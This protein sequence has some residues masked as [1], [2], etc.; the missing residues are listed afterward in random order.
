MLRGHTQH[1][2]GQRSRDAGKEHKVVDGRCT[3]AQRL[4]A[5]VFDGIPERE[6]LG[7]VGRQVQQRRLRRSR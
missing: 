3:Q 4:L 2:R 5:E 1:A 7:I 6:C